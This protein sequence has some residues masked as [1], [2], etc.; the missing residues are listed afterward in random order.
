MNP[1][2]SNN[3]SK[4]ITKINNTSS[5]PVKK[6]ILWT[7]ITNSKSTSPHMK[8][9]TNPNISKIKLIKSNYSGQKL[10]NNSLSKEKS[11]TSPS[12]KTK[13]I[14]NLENNKNY[15]NNSKITTNQILNS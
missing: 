3:K 5:K 15:L 6:M 11:T 8:Q 2:N 9:D 13:D 1:N 14:S 10:K 4:I 7:R 12:S